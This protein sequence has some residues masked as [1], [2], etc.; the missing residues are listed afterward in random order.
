MKDYM[1]SYQPS[2][3]QYKSIFSN[4]TSQTLSKINIEKYKQQFT[5]AASDFSQ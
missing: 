1:A 2:Y 5:T 3:H 4:I